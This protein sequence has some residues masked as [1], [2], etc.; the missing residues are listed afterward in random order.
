MMMRSFRTSS[1]S[2][3]GILEV[4]KWMAEQAAMKSA[5]EVEKEGAAAEGAAAQE[6]GLLS[7]ICTYKVVG[8]TQSTQPMI[9]YMQYARS[10][11][12]N[13]KATT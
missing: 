5:P 3:E 4:F 2:G 6:E 11:E 10:M 9:I 12:R 8:V 1:K 13:R 7:L